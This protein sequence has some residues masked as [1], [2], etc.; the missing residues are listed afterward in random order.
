MVLGKQ[1]NIFPN[2]CNRQKEKGRKKGGRARGKEG[3]EIERERRRKGGK[4][5]FVNSKGQKWK[6]TSS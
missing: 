1:S 2:Y 6:I 3:R 4:K 5:V